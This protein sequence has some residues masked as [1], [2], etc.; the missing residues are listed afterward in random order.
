M[1][2]VSILPIT[3]VPLA[4]VHFALLLKWLSQPHVKTWWD[5]DIE[6]TINLV[7]EKYGTYIRGYKV[8]D[9]AKKPLQGY[10]IQ[11]DAIPIGYIQVYNVH[12]FPRKNN[13]ADQLPE[14]CAALDFYIGEE[15]YIGKRIGV[16]VL[17]TFLQ[18]HVWPR[19]EACLVDPDKNN[20]AAIKTYERLGFKYYGMAGKSQLMIASSS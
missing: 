2:K 9:G 18:Q 19:Y 4:T 15:A 12:D 7:Q 10:I 13:S 20:I 5:S 11:Y 8:V 6:W 1:T 16:A 17:T 14:S 3:F